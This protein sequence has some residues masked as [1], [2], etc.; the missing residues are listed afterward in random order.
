MSADYAT[1]T[2]MNMYRTLTGGAHVDAYL[3][4]AASGYG[5]GWWGV[6]YCPSTSTQGGTHPYRWCRPFAVKFNSGYYPGAFDSVIE[7][8]YVACHELGHTA[9]LLDRPYNGV[10]YQNSCMIPDYAFYSQTTNADDRAH[11]NSNY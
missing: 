7:R 8:D 2:D 10:V 4:Q 3:Y 5:S 9:G 6:T 11:L 1:P